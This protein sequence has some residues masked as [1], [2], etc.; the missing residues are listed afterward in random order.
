[1]NATRVIVVYCLTDV[2]KDEAKADVGYQC[3]YDLIGNACMVEAMPS[4]PHWVIFGTLSRLKISTWRSDIG[5]RPPLT[6]CPNLRSEPAPHSR[7]GIFSV[8]C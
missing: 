2:T 8:V 3:S 6:S 4:S 1:M 5:R 7:V